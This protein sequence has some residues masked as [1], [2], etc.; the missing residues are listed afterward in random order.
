MTIQEAIDKIQ[1]ELQWR[2]KPR[3]KGMYEITMPLQDKRKYALV[4]TVTG[5]QLISWTR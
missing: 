5:K 3:A 2:V 1:D 4:A